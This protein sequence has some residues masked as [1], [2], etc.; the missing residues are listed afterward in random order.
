METARDPTTIAKG[1]HTMSSVYEKPVSGSI[2]EVG[3]RLVRAVEL[4]KYGVLGTI[5]LKEK[6]NGKGVEFEPAC[7]VYEVCNPVKASEVL[8]H[9]MSVST[10]LPCRISIYE[11]GGQL[12]LAT[13]KPTR[14]LG[15]FGHEELNQQA[16]QVEQ[17]LIAIIDEVAGAE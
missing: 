3:E 8:Q 2:D 4:H 7:R 14:I 10:A 17:D 6:M 5:D 11:F 12:R 9:D 1:E 13:L 15:V 16:L